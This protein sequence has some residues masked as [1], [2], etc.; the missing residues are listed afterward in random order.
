[1]SRRYLFGPVTADFAEQNLQP[2][3][4]NGACLVFGPAGAA[5]LAIGVGDSW[6]AVAA[7]FP[8][9][10]RPDFVALALPSANV[11]ACLWSAPVPLVGLAHDWD[12]HWHYYRR[13][14]RSCDLILTDTAGVETLARAGLAQAR[15]ANLHGLE[16]AFLETSWPDG[17]R[18]IDILYAGDLHPALQRE[19]LPWM[20]RLANLGE[21]WRVV[22]HPGASGTAYRDLLARARIVFYR[23]RHGECRRYLLEA[24]AAGALVFH[25]LENREVA[26]YLQE[27][28]DCAGYIADRHIVDNLEQRLEYCLTHEDLR[29]AMVAAARARVRCYGFTDFWEEALDRLEREWPAMQTR[30]NR[31]P[32]LDPGDDLQ[33]RA[34]LALTSASSEDAALV[35]DL[36]AAVA[37]EPRSASLHNFIGLLTDPAS[38][39]V[40]HFRTALARD[41]GH[42]MAG[43]NLA[44]AL[45]LVGDNSQ[46]LD[47]ARRT[48]TILD[49]QASL[50]PLVLDAGH[51]PRGMDLFQV[52]WQRAAWMNAGQ[53]ASGA[54]ETPEATAKRGLLRWRLH[55]LL[56]E[57][58]GGLAHW[59]EA[60]LTRPDLPTTRAAIGKAL[61][62]AGFPAE[63]AVHLN[64]A[65][66][67]NPFDRDT[68]RTLFQVLGDL[69]HG[70]GQRALAREWQML[71][72]AAPQLATAEA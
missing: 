3:R 39:A 9:G 23:G 44:E 67:A 46:A 35:R 42:V 66:N 5:D 20:S 57:G 4:R 62:S 12:Q 43:L 18:D 19:F 68:V 64:Q 32:A 63:A 10:W 50:D 40:E 24:A 38:T 8:A 26:V 16:R 1:M 51:F 48:L 14:L 15:F 59:Y 56:G 37:A 2:Q 52:E 61:A 25:E 69:N 27:R 6:D 13:R 71:T 29:R 33:A 70:E 72:R 34:W 49:R 30:A 55:A 22:I 41:P 31:R 47:Q 58:P 7:R 21:R 54:P 11:P 60:V 36:A 53:P 45:N 65:V 17:Q 28:R